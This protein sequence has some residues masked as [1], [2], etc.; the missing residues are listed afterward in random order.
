MPSLFF[1][2]AIAWTPI[3]PIVGV[4]T[5][6]QHCLVSVAYAEMQGYQVTPKCQLFVAEEPKD[7]PPDREEHDPV[8]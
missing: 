6:K 1:W 8:H 7:I 4:F 5:D 3:G 2:L